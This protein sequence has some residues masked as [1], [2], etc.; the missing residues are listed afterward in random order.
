MNKKRE[1]LLVPADSH[2]RHKMKVCC[3]GNIGTGLFVGQVASTRAV[4]RFAYTGYG[5]VAA[6]Q[7][8]EIGEFEWDL[9]HQRM[10]CSRISAV[11]P[12]RLADE[13]SSTTVPS[14]SVTV[15]F[16]R[17]MSTDMFVGQ[18]SAT[19]A[20]M[21]FACAG[22]GPAKLHEQLDIDGLVWDTRRKVFLCSRISQ[23]NA[24]SQVVRKRKSLCA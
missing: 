21:R 24:A 7:D 20:I 15:F 13:A 2:S 22:V 5:P 23:W 6:R 1:G 17:K 19:N 4:L 12:T 11:L 8:L 3:L 10:K 9:Q 14:E 16:L 18:V